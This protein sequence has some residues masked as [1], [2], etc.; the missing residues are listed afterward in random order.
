MMDSQQLFVVVVVATAWVQGGTAIISWQFFVRR[1]VD[2]PY[3]H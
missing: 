2:P 1:L 3:V